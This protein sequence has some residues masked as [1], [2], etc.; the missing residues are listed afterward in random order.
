ML[1]VT[2]SLQGRFNYYCCYNVLLL[3]LLIR[4]HSE[5]AYCELFCFTLVI[6][7]FSLLLLNYVIFK[8]DNPRTTQPVATK[9]CMVI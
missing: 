6:Y 9:F 7:F 8:L 5:L 3:E 2:D 1:I 4:A